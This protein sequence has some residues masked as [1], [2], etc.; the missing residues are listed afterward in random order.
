MGPEDV[1]FFVK[2]SRQNQSDGRVAKKKYN[3][4]V[5][6]KINLLI[7]LVLFESISSDHVPSPESE[8]AI[9]VQHHRP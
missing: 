1:S 5:K 2:L 6:N 8:Y 7:G 4:A 9:A 3:V